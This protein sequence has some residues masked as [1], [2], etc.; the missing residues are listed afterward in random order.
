LIQSTVPLNVSNLPDNPINLNS[1]NHKTCVLTSSGAVYCWGSL[2]MG[3]LSNDSLFTTVPTAIPG[4]ESG[5]T[6]LVS[7]ADFSCVLTSTGSVKCWGGN[8]YGQLGNGTNTNSNSL[9]D[10]VDLSSGVTALAAGYS[11]ACAALNSGGVKCWG[12]NNYYQLGNNSSSNSNVPVNVAGLSSKI[13]AVTAGY[14]HTCALTEN[15]GVRCWGNNN[16]G[17]LGDGSNTNQQTAVTVSGL[18]TAVTAITAGY[19]HTCALTSDGKVKCWGSND[20]KSGDGATEN[21]NTP[22]DVTGLD[23]GVTSLAAGYTRTC[24]LLNSGGVKCWGKNTDGFLGDGTL[25]KHL[26]PVDVKGLSQG[27]V[28]ISAGSEHVCA[29]L[30]GGRVKC[31]GTND[32]GQLGQGNSIY[33][34][35]TTPIDV[36]SNGPQISINYPDG[37]PG[38]FFTITGANFPANSPVSIK[39]NGKVLSQTINTNEAGEFIFF[40]ST[41]SD[42]A[43]GEY[44]LI[45]SVESSADIAAG[46]LSFD[47]DTSASAVFTLSASA[48]LRAQEG[49]GDTAQIETGVDPT[50]GP[51]VQPTARPTIQPTAVPTTQPTAKPTEASLYLPVVTR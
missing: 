28:A 39:A 29:M 30:S 7:G 41:P 44:T 1:G 14:D 42:F 51:T 15:G 48:P 4:L 18:S 2:D 9:V 25:T 8:Y 11:H 23:Q 47:E 49:G 33:G 6:A 27:V 19:H 20:G 32:F 46:L 31:W 37:K 35:Q 13:T 21:N 40:L 5:I 38:S 50:P 45:V 10:V 12:W 34:M 26:I 3:T 24:A 17:E 36:E 22:V 43:E 16:F